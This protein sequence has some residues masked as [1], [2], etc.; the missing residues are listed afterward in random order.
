[1]T[2]DVFVFSDEQ[3]LLRETVRD[4]CQRAWP[5][6]DVARAAHDD[7]AAKFWTTLATELGVVGLTVPEELG[8]LGAG[9]VDLVVVAEELGRVMA[10]SPL[11]GTT[12]VTET[13]VQ[14]GGD[15]AATV[16]EQVLGGHRLAAL[17]GTDDA[18]RWR[19]DRPVTAARSGD[20]GWRIDGTARGV[21]D[22]A[23]A[24]DLL[25]L[26]STD[27]GIA[28]MLVDGAADGI[29]RRAVD[30]MDLTREL[31]DVAFANT[32]ALPVGDGQAVVDAVQGA[33]D[34]AT[35]VLAAEQL[36]GCQAMLDR[37][38]EHARTHMQFGRPIG[39]FQAVR[40]RC[41]DMLVAT[42]HARSAVYHA[43]WTAD[44][45]IDDVG[46]ASS[47]AHVVASQAHTEVSGGALQLHGG[48]GFTWEHPTHLYLKRAWSDATLLGGRAFH[49]ARL[50][51]LLEPPAA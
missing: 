21:L 39:T 15:A 13:L 47:L 19:P 38:A 23:T 26:S 4:A 29:T 44:A 6:E 3:Q 43:A 1:M 35:I 32:R 12:L 18:G 37:T 10:A 46:L 48:I 17:V 49:R 40:H 7:R 8:G 51:P 33:A 24:D 20:D 50:A 9:V 41:A 30:T 11:L 5:P 31:A 16:L 22:G 14:L 27:D 25:V 45:G 2:T 42:E 34:V 28:L 36:G